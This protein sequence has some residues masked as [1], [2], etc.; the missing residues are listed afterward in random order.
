MYRDAE[1]RLVRYLDDNPPASDEWTSRFKLSDDPRV[2]PGVGHFLRRFSIDELPQLV[3]VLRLEMSLVGPRPFP[4]YHLEA[5]P[6]RFRELRRRVRPGM[7]GLW[8]VSVRGDGDLEA[9]QAHDT[10]YIRAWS[11]WLDLYLL[12]RTFLA[13]IRSRG[14]Y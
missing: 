3:N 14:A 9:Q 1:H 6:A 13:V 7:T 11:P 12:A 8:Q 2:L 10:Y 4:D 5:F